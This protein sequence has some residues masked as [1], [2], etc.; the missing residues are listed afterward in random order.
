MFDEPLGQSRVIGCQLFCVMAAQIHQHIGSGFI[1]HQFLCHS[2]LL[3]LQLDHL[4]RPAEVV[5]QGVNSFHLLHSFVVEAIP[6]AFQPD[7]DVVMS[8]RGLT[9]LV[10]QN[11][12]EFVGP[13]NRRVECPWRKIDALGV[14]ASLEHFFIGFVVGV[15]LKPFQL[16]HHHRRQR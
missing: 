16:Q 8:R 2:Q 5:V 7:E 12:I 3:G 15:K 13:G 11:R 1:L 9:S 4:C 10:D 14:G 6:L